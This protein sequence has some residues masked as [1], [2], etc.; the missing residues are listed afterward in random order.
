MGLAQAY[1][2][3]VTTYEERSEYMSGFMVALMAGLS[4]GPVCGGYLTVWLGWR[5][6]IAAAALLTET[7]DAAKSCRA[8][9]RRGGGSKGAFEA[10]ALWGLLKNDPNPEKY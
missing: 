4:I 5:G 3:D 7:A 10:G 1:I 8:L 9:A 2:A 6:A